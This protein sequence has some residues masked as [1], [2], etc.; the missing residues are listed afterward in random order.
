MQPFRDLGLL[1]AFGLKVGD[2]GCEQWSLFAR[3]CFHHLTGS[4]FLQQ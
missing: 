2:L 1:E 3:L 4:I